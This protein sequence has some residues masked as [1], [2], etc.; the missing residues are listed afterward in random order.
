MNEQKG[1]KTE[2]LKPTFPKKV[3]KIK[4]EFFLF[5]SLQGVLCVS[6]GLG[7]RSGTGDLQGSV[8]WDRPW[9]LQRG[10]R[11]QG[12]TEGSRARL[13]RAPQDCPPRAPVIAE[14]ASA[15]RRVKG[16]DTREEV[17]N[18][19]PEGGL[20][21]RGRL[22]HWDWDWTQ[23]WRWAGHLTPQARATGV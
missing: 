15:A 13:L 20:H 7:G 18:M 4:H 11:G 12:C 21:P 14:L 19:Q 2:N 5:W 8:R 3:F 17:A 22:R 16:E 1:K 6:Q 10:S 9:E 23:G